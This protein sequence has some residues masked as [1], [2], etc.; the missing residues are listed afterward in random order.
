MSPH[1]LKLAAKVAAGSKHPQHPMAAILLRGGAV[2]AAEANGGAGRGHAE[3]RVLRPHLDAR[4]THLIVLRLNGRRVSRPCDRCIAK[5][6]L[7]GVKRV[8]F[9][10]TDG[11][12]KTVAVGAL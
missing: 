4:G 12:W 9:V 3:A 10:D 5:I 11:C 1:I 8:S 7:A 2:V 6:Q